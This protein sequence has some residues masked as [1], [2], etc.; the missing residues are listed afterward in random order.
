MTYADTLLEEVQADLDAAILENVLLR[1]AVNDFCLGRLTCHHDHEGYFLKHGD[2][3][4][5]GKHYPTALEA[6]LAMEGE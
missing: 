4:D 6:V 3:P 2:A 1:K 5:R